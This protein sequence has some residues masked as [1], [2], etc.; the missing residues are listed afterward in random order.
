MGDRA[1]R[2]ATEG[3][4]SDVPDPIGGNETPERARPRGTARASA[5]PHLT[6]RRNG[7]ASLG[8]SPVEVKTVVPD[9]VAPRLEFEEF[10]R[11]E[12]PGLVRAFYVLTADWAEAEELAQEAMARAYERW[13]RVGAMESPA[14]YLYRVGVNLNRH[15][16][17]HLAVRARRLLAMTRDAGSEQAPGVRREIAEAIASL[18]RGQREAFML[19]EWLGLNAEEAGQVLGIASAS[20]RSRVHRTKAALRDRLSDEGGE[21]WTT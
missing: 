21:P 1:R 16:L 2:R 15:R 7:R 13:E 3:D 9:Q 18:S 11:A 12:Y 8:I 19:V 20:V 14:G 6:T 5:Y 17:R 4:D 10:F